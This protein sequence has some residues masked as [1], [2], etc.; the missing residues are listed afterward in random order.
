[1][2]AMDEPASS[3]TKPLFRRSEVSLAEFPAGVV[4][5]ARSLGP[6]EKTRAF[7][8]T[9]RGGERTHFAHDMT[10]EVE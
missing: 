3:R 2:H 7:G 9:P 4:I 8:M 6:L 1:M 5:R 10:S